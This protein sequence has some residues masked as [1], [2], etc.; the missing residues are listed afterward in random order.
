MDNSQYSMNGGG[1]AT[2]A[3]PAYAEDIALA[4]QAAAQDKGAAP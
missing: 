2:W 4:I 3:S 1:T